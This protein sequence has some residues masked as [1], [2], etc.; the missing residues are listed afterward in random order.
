MTK[1]I[2]AVNVEGEGRD[3]PL[4]GENSVLLGYRGN[5]QNNQDITAFLTKFSCPMTQSKP[6]PPVEA[7]GK[8]SLDRYHQAIETGAF[9]DWNVELLDGELFEMSPE[10]PLHS[11]KIGSAGRYLQTI[12]PM[13]QAW[14]RFGNPVTLSNSEPE[15]DI[16]IVRPDPDEYWD[17]HPGLDDILLLI[18]FSDSSLPKDKDPKGKKYITYAKEGILDYWIVDLKNQLLQVNRKPQGVQYLSRIEHQKATIKP[19]LLDTVIDVVRL[20]RGR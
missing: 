7:K 4:D 9:T 8:W 16:A 12:L 3:R 17:R 15:P 13:T 20:L 18:E 10:G 14:L 19:L 1:I 6:I 11:G 5:E 2:A